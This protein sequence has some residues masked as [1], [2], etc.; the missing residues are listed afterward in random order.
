MM[1][2]LLLF[3]LIL[4]FGNMFAQTPPQR[5]CGTMQHHNYLLQTRPNYQN[6]LMQYEQVINQYLQDKASGTLAAR[7]S[8]NPIVTIPVVVHVLYNGAAENI[9]DAQAASQVQV[10]NDDF[11]KFNADASKVTQPAF[12]A[13]ASGANIRF[14]LA[15]RDPSGNATTGVVHKATTVGSFGTNDAVKHNS[16]GGDDAWDVTRYVNI[17]VCDLGSQLLGYGEFPT[18]SLSNT[19]GLVIHYKYTG[20]GGSAMAPYNLG[21]TGTHEFGHCFNLL[22]IWGDDGTGCSGS[23]QCSDT[24]N[25]AGEHY[26]CFAQGSIQTDGCTGSSPGVMWMNYMDYT[27]DACMYMFTAQQCARMEAVVNTAPWNILQSSNGCTPV[28]SLDAGVSGIISPVNGSSACITGVTPK[29][30]LVNAGSTTLT[31][32]KVLYKM[33]ATATQTLNWSGSLA[34]SASTVLTLNSYT[35]LT[36]A[37]HTFS[38]WV[39]APNGSTDQNAANNAMVSNFTVTA[40][41]TGS[42]LPFTEGFETTTFPPAGWQLLR[43]ATVNT[44]NSWSRLAN[45]TG[46]TAGSTAI[47]K[48]DNYSGSTLDITGQLDALRSPALDFSAANSSLKVRFDVSHRIYNTSTSDSLNV[49]ISTDCATTWT[50]LYTKGGSQLATVTGGQTSAYTPSANAQWRRDSINLSAYAGQ[51]SVYLKFESR[52]NWGNN[53]YLDNIN[54]RNTIAAAPTA[55]FASVP[56]NCPGTTITLADQ[57]LNGPTSWSWSM[58]GASPAT[59]TAQNPSITYTAGGTYT[60]SLTA[61]NATGSGTPYT[62]VVTVNPKPAVAVAS[63]TV[64]AGTSATITASGASSYAW[65]TGQSTAAIANAPAATTVYTVTGTSAASCTNVATGTITVKALPAVTATS[66]TIC[67]GA[68]AVITA[69]GASTYTWTSGPT[70]AAYAVSPTATSTYTVSGTGSNACVNTK[71][72]SVTVN[73]LPSTSVISA[74][75]CAGATGTLSASGASTYSWNTGATGANLT[76]SPSSNTSYTVTG[77][78]A[79]GCVKTATASITVGSAPAISLSSATVCAGGSV[80]LSASGVTSYTWTSGPNT[81]TYSVT[82]SATTVYTVSGTLA[83]CSTAAIKTATVTVNALPNVSASSATICAGN[84]ANLTAS[85]ASSYAW[86]TGA[87]TANTSVSPSATTVYTVT[88]TSAAGCVNTAIANV[89]VNA[90]P[91][92]SVSSVTICAGSPANLNASGASSYVWNTGATTANISVSPASTTMYTVTGSSAQGCTAGATAEV[93]VTAAPVITVNSA[94]VCAGS[95]ALLTASGVTSYT[96]NTGANGSGL[97]VSP[98]STTVYTVSGN[99]AGCS[100]QAVQTATVTVYALP[101][102]NLALAMDVAC[103]NNGPVNMN[104]TPAGGS[105][106]GTGVSGNTFNPSGTGTYTITY[107]YTNSN[108]CTNSSSKT[109][110]VEL[111]TGLEEINGGELVIYPNPAKETLTVKFGAMPDNAATVE[112]YDAIGK[113]VVSQKA[114]EQLVIVDVQ[115]FAKGIYT[116]RIVSGN[117]QVVRRIVKE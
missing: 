48:M 14:C 64:C 42:A 10:L 4:F 114:T 28:T 72:T 115:A 13:V 62:Q 51:P 110:T 31:S 35:G 108:G 7:T 11:A 100:T 102:V 78:S 8:S 43:A 54:V 53:L 69:G 12:A 65:N 77:T 70:T 68:S 22:H 2:R 88:G 49:Y 66:A 87:T 52:S 86:N 117:S 44:V 73:A 41:P 59:S 55:S 99:L 84:T 75:I 57:S 38:V 36:A 26:G 92:V 33:D 63:A 56:A 81:A 40:V 61:T 104:G 79:S 109:I 105:Y 27:D 82:P 74:T 76:A 30:N 83:G 46:L 39:T 37:A 85:G 89:L 103:V 17:W 113:L 90:L 21:R 112:L 1:K 71:T 97:S 3:G 23:D 98:S 101:S 58:P 9:T 93:Y 67:A 47:A 91:N 16:S 34:T 19:W 18:T 111:C 50:R 60:I 24:P 45:T 25:Q 15:Q 107:S 29:I 5:N 6:E 95:A 96:W 116:L 20:S 32:V 80:L 106:S 94:S